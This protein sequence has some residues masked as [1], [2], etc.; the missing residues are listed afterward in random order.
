MLHCIARTL[1]SFPQL[2]WERFVISDAIFNKNAVSHFQQKA[3]TTFKS[4]V[5]ASPFM[6]T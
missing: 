1:L 4:V 2:V 5:C 3:Q 6:S